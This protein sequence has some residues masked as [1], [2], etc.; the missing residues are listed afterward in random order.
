MWDDHK[1]RRG[2]F[3]I[4]NQKGR[5]RDT[6]QENGRSGNYSAVSDRWA[7]HHFALPNVEPPWHQN[8]FYSPAHHIPACTRC[9]H[10]I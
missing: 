4:E 9:E 2:D 3:F 1:A 5:K 6:K 8:M 7:N 10:K